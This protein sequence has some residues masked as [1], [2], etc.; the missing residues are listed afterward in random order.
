MT[1]YYVTGWFCL[2]H[3]H[4][5]KKNEKCKSFSHQMQIAASEVFLILKKPGFLNSSNNLP[6]CPKES[7]NNHNEMSPSSQY[8]VRTL[9]SILSPQRIGCKL[10]FLNTSIFAT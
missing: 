6:Y 5:L 9:I 7:G 8:T 10:I 2:Y 4:M 3:L 1:Q